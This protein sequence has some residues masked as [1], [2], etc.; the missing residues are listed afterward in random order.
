MFCVE[1][2]TITVYYRLAVHPLSTLLEDSTLLGNIKW[3]YSLLCHCLGAVQP[4]KHRQLKQLT[5]ISLPLLEE[6]LLQVV[7]AIFHLWTPHGES[8]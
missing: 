3:P 6:N 5:V 1:S 8:A 4:S 7:K 2:R